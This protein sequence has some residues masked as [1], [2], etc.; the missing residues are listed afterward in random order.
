MQTLNTVKQSVRYLLIHLFV[1]IN[2]LVVHL[3]FKQ[4][5]DD[6][7]LFLLNSLIH[8][9]LHSAF[10]YH[11]WWEFIVMLT[12]VSQLI[13]ITDRVRLWQWEELISELK[14][15]LNRDKMFNWRRKHKLSKFL[16]EQCESRRDTERERFIVS[17]LA[18][19]QKEL[20]NSLI[21]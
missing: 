7:S 14:C 20:K 1:L 2:K 10:I 5:L 13:K 12:F 15:R 9:I 11:A 3:I 8:L 4:A 6:L 19:N 17:I 16:K 18:L 21:C